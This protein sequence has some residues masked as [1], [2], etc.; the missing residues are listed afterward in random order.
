MSAIGR[1]PVRVRAYSDMHTRM[2][3]D[4]RAAQAAEAERDK[5]GDEA[6][7]ASE[8]GE[9]LGEAQ[10]E[11]ERRAKGMAAA[12]TDFQSECDALRRCVH[13]GVRLY[14]YPNAT[15]RAGLRAR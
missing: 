9:A 1:V 10:R 15:A 12:I 4:T 8:R 6:A 7:R 11:A 3:I 5:R 2:P 14:A 13:S